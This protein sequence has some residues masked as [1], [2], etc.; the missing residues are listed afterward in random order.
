M[1]E[2]P[3]ATA[4]SSSAL[5]GVHHDLHLLAGRALEFAHEQRDALED[6]G[7]RHHPDAEI[8]AR[9]SR[10]WRPFSA[11][12]A[13]TSRTSTPCSASFA[14]ARAMKTRD[15]ERRE[16]LHRLV[17][18]RDL[19]AHHVGALELLPR[20]P[21]RSASSSGAAEERIGVEDAR[22]GRREGHEL[23][24]RD[25][26]RGGHLLVAPARGDMSAND[27]PPLASSAAGTERGTTF[28]ISATWLTRHAPT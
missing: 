23:V 5:P 2:E 26:R 28:T 12:I 11:R 1:A 16:P 21:P 20:A 14:T 13:A 19:H 22:A 25:P 24:R 4:L 6:L 18:A 8:A 9:M 3:S 10:S 27:R 17:H 7:D 15:D